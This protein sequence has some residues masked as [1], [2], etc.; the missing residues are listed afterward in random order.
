M[1]WRLSCAVRCAEPPPASSC[2]GDACSADQRARAYSPDVTAMPLKVGE[3]DIRTIY[4]LL[5]LVR[6]RPGMWIGAPSVTRLS[7]FIQ[8]FRIG[9]DAAHGSLEVEHPAFHDFHDWVAA[10]LRR[11][12]NGHGWS[13]MLLEA[14]NGDEEAAFEQ[15]WRELDVFRSQ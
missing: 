2:D 7:V 14:A 4:D 6:E 10:Q 9:V 5:D 12:K 13:E 8:G 3:R 1:T 15:F 11:P